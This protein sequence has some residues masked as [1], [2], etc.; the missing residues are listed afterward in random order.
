MI[1]KVLKKTERE[2]PRLLS[3][4]HEAREVGM[5]CLDASK[6]SLLVT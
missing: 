4:R 1:Y 5:S 3:K 6:A 2:C